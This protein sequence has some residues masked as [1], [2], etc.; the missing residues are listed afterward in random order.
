VSDLN[1]RL[2]AAG[3]NLVA[4]RIHH[5]ILPL[6]NGHLILIV[7]TT[8]NFTNLAGYPGTTAVLGDALV[9]LDTN[10]QPVWEWSS[11]DHLDLNRHPMSFPD[12]THSNAVLHSPDDSNLLLYLVASRSRRG[13][14]VEWGHRSERL[15][16]RSARSQNSEPKQHWLVYDRPI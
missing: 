16:L 15:V 13:F 14:Y 6:P 11:F 1:A 2:A 12:W 8:Q 7:N 3:F 10:W 4:D 5:D 9:D